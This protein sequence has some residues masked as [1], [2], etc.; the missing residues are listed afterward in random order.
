MCI[1][2]QTLVRVCVCVCV[3]SNQP[4]ASVVRIKFSWVIMMIIIIHKNITTATSFGC[5]VVCPNFSLIVSHDDQTSHLT[6][7]ADVFG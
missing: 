7:I 1:K 6:I 5:L 3:C 4:S 2:P